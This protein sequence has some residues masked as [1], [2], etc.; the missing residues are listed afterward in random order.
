M[1]ILLL[2]GLLFL[3]LISCKENSLKQ[4]NDLAQLENS[5]NEFESYGEK[6]S[7][8]NSLSA[9]E[10]QEVYRSLKPGDTV[11]AKFSTEVLSVCKMKG[12]WITLALPGEDEDPMVKFKNYGFFVPKDIAGK[13][14]IVEGIAFIEETSVED[15]RHF[16]QD[17]GKSAGEVEAI[18]E[19]SI[20]MGFL[21]NGVL[22][23]K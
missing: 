7:P 5:Q 23:K 16:A 4:N 11:N 12:C 18:T 21:A 1:K 14:V 20:S 17:A 13:E 2:T 10:M 22:I 9:K 6:I 19:P 15:R 8:D 3:S